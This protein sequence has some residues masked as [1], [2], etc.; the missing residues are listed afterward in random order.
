LQSCHGGGELFTGPAFVSIWRFCDEHMFNIREFKLHISGK[1][2]PQVRTF[3][4]KFS[5]NVFVSYFLSCV[6][7]ISMHCSFKTTS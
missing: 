2:K 5:L 3:L 7:R 4:A 1:S 6:E